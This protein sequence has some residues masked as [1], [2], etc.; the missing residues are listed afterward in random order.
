MK[1]IQIAV[2]LS[3]CLASFVA[4]ARGGGHTSS[5]RSSTSH[6]HAAS[7]YGTG[8]SS[9]STRASGYT[10]HN[11]THVAPYHRTTPDSTR[12]NNYSTKGNVNPYTGAVGSKSALP[13]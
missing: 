1:K 8:S 7:S 13:R 3:L 4:V 5:A 9:S 10:T 2:A 12:S 11:G 6:S